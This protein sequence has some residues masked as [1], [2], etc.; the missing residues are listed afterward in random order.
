MRVVLSR[1]VLRRFRAADL[2][3]LVRHANDRR[4]A[5]SVRDVFPSPYTRADG[6]R[7]LAHATAAGRANNLAIEIDG[8]VAGGIGMIPGEDV[9]RI[10][11]EIGY[12]LGHAFWGRGVMTE[13]VTFFSRQ[14]LEDRGFLRLEAPV[15]E[16]NPASAR[17]LEKSGFALESRQ[18]R[19][20]IK[21]GRV[22]DLL[23]YVKLAPP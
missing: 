23:L 4:V 1:C 19:A 15:F 2:H 17:V 5:A 3:S 14:L 21:D 9:H 10:R 7:W 13:A 6:E 12:W 11:A 22:L 16:T 8:E 20:V 18:R